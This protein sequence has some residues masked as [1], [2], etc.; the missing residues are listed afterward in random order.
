MATVATDEIKWLAG[1]LEDIAPSAKL[2]GIVG[3]LA[4][5]RRGGYHISRQDQPSTNYSVRKPI[6]KKGR[7]DAAAAIDLNLKLEDMKKIHGRLVK[8]FKARDE[9]FKYVNA[10]NGWDGSGSAGRYECDDWDVGSSSADHKWHIHLEIHRAYVESMTAMKAILSLFKGETLAQYKAS[11]GKLPATKPIAKPVVVKPKDED[12]AEGFKKIA[13]LQ[14]GSN[15]AAVKKLQEGLKRVFPKYAGKLV[16]DG[17]FGPA[18]KK[19]VMEFQ[20]RSD[21]DDDGIVGELTQKA[22]FKY[23]IELR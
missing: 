3:D 1:E 12:K 2:S 21:L 17:D 11:I 14:V 7:K 20:E 15:G 22:L 8:A 4:H 16:V 23:G 18:T 6:D 10:W 19:A 13:D 9:R 5:K